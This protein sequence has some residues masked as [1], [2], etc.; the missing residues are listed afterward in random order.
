MGTKD[1]LSKLMR[2]LI[3]VRHAKSDWGNESLPDFF[4]PLNERG[5][6]DAPE[7]AGRL[8][9]LG[10]KPDLVISS[11][12]I[13]AYSTAQYFMDACHISA[14]RMWLEPSLYMSS[15]EH[16]K[17]TIS[18]LPDE[19]DRVMLFGHN[20][21]ITQ[22]TNLL[23]NLKTDNVPTCGM[24]AFSFGQAHWRDVS[25]G[26]MIFFEFPKKSPL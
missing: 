12:A 20:P 25:S 15:V 4:R 24:A 2:T 26:K 7:M 11:P 16:Y 3:L 21:M 5:N 6:R 13:R 8:H 10:I 14:D 18:G 17:R 19:V 9:K 22:M 23:G 1:V